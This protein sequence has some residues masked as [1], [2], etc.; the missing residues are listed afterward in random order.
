MSPLTPTFQLSLVVSFV[1]QPKEQRRTALKI[2]VSSPIHEH[3]LLFHLQQAFPLEKHRYF[4]FR[5]L[6]WLLA[7]CVFSSLSQDCGLEALTMHFFKCSVS[8]VC[9]FWF[10]EFWKRES[11]TWLISS[12]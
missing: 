3:N 10:A 11:T 4:L 6:L 2:A 7:L 5:E 8:V 12:I 9:S 1:S